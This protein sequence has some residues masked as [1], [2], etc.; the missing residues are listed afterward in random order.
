VEIKDVLVVRR[1]IKEELRGNMYKKRS[2]KKKT[3]K[4]LIEIKTNKKGWFVV[5]LLSINKGNT[6]T[7]R[8]KDGQIIKRK[9]TNIRWSVSK[10]RVKLQGKPPT[11]SMKLKA[12][13]SKKRL[14]KSKQVRHKK[15]NK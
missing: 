6:I 7:I 12:F 15:S 11:S 14:R 5:E 9:A 1:K 13:K 4:R 3:Y 2:Y 8:I 10:K